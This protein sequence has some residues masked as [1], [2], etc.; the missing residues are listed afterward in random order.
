MAEPSVDFANCVQ[1]LEHSAALMRLFFSS[2]LQLSVVG[3]GW[4]QYKTLEYWNVQIMCFR[5][6]V[7]RDCQEPTYQ[8][9]T[10]FQTFQMGIHPMPC[11]STLCLT[12]FSKQDMNKA[13]IPRGP[14]LKT[15][16]T[17]T[18]R[19]AAKESDISTNSSQWIYLTKDLPSRIY[20]EC[21]QIKDRKYDSIRR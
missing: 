3:M 13:E 12:G 8:Y 18:F 4:N 7:V 17:R 20:Q 11:L 19:G 15:L 9:S 1:N 10:S 2:L 16:L 5:N 14:W 21:L 6:Y